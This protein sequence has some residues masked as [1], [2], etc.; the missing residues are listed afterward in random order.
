MPFNCVLFGC[1]LEG[2]KFILFCRSEGGSSKM[3]TLAIFWYSLALLHRLWPYSL[4]PDNN[5]SQ[6]IAE[7]DNDEGGLKKGEILASFFLDEGQGCAVPRAEEIVDNNKMLTI[8]RRYHLFR[9]RQINQSLYWKILV[10][11]SKCHLLE[12]GVFN[13][14]FFS[15]AQHAY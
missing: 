3:A 1:Y 9:P 12:L 4:L 8:Y 13:C 6:G 2:W 14:I 10:K 15:T 11:A 5:W 7:E